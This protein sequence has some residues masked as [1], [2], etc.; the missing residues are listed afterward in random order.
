VDIGPI[1]TLVTRN[2]IDGWRTRL[3]AQTTGNLNHHLF[4]KGYYAR[5]WGSKKNYYKG[6]FVY[7]FNRKNYTF[8]EFPRRSLT[9]E[10]TYD[11]MSPSDKFLIT[12]KDNV[13]TSFHWTT[14]DKMMFYNRQTIQF[15]YETDYNFAFTASLKAEENEAAGNMKALGYDFTK[16]NPAD[17]AIPYPEINKF[18]TT[19]FTAKIR[20][21]P[22]EKYMN[23]KQRRV[24]VNQDA[25]IF[26]L[27]HTVGMKN[28]LGG[29]YNYNYT[30]ATAYYRLWLNS[31]GK[32]ELNLR[33]GIQ[34]NQVPF[35]LL[36]MPEANLSFVSAPGTF[37]MVNN[38]EF[39]S[40]RYASFQMA[41]DMKGKIF[42]RV[43]LLRKLKLREYVGYKMMWGTLTDKNSLY[44]PD[45]SYAL[46]YKK[47]YMEW[48]VGVHNIFKILRVEYVHRMN[49]TDLPTAKK[50]G[51]R[52]FFNF[53]F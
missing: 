40:D 28:F 36:I 8:D 52:F 5:G 18:R 6:T 17:A 32:M 4:F 13:F 15:D 20:Y 50:H 31:W 53:T 22:G 48:A 26:I 23:T 7:S 19:E 44:L 41:W 25:P 16:M 11:V 21:A 45:E 9:L 30:E 46:D 42:N 29:D 43:P 47:P 1:N 27:S 24:K 39:L 33:A 34:W 51:I 3:S 49:Y 10:S 38:M 14:V 12:D 2:F 37:S 35:V